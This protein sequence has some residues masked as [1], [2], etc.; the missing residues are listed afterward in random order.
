MPAA[1]FSS[2][3]PDFSPEQ[4][5]QCARIVAGLRKVS[6][7]VVRLGGS[8][9]ALTSTADQVEALLASL[10][11]VT[12]A[13][14]MESYRFAFDLDRPND[15]LPFNPATGEFNPVAPSLKMSVERKK[16]LIH[17]EFPNCYESA[18]DTVQ[19]GMVAAVYDQ[20][21][22]YAV[23]VEGLT[24][25]TLSIRVNFLKPTPINEPLRFEAAVD[26]IDGKKYSVKG[27]C[28]RGEEKVTEAE[29]LILGAYELTLLGGDRG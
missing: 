5:D 16:L 7:K 10:D 27:S 2:H 25:P 22:A 11:G 4:E 18:P 17:C 28:Y 26:S 9:D 20:L 1:D 6:A 13:R 21:L 19:G 29:A 23:M 15:V 3:D 14:A 12:Q 8:L 24:G